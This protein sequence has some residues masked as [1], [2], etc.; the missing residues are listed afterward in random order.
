MAAGFATIA[1]SVLGAY[2][3]FGVRKFGDY[4]M[5]NTSSSVFAIVISFFSPLRLDKEAKRVSFVLYSWSQFLWH[6]N[7]VTPRSFGASFSYLC[8]LK[9]NYMQP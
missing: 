6:L 2:I 7:G 1:G 8:H 9:V 3:S 5:E 4:F